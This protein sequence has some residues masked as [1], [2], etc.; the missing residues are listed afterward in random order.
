MEFHAPPNR[1]RPVR[2]ALA[3]AAIATVLA[4]VAGIGTVPVTVAVALWWL[5]AMAFATVAALSGT[6]RKTWSPKRARHPRYH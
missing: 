5:G 2:L 3:A 6:R 1:S 4:V